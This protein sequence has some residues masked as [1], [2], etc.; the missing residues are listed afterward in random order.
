MTSVRR[1]AVLQLF[2]VPSHAFLDIFKM[3]VSGIQR[4]IKF[5][6]VNILLKFLKHYER[7]IFFLFVKR[8]TNGRFRYC[9][10]GDYK[11]DNCSCLQ[12]PVCQS[13]G[14]YKVY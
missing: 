2:Q 10:C 3:D 7:G 14:M 4:F 5:V 1:I 6:N 13:T 12:A 11:C 8:Y 9:G